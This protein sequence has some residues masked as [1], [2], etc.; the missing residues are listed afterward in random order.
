MG[1]D[2]DLI[3]YAF[4][5]A[6]WE[7]RSPDQYARYARVAL[8]QYRYILAKP[9]HDDMKWPTQQIIA[10]ELERRLGLFDK[11]RTRFAKLKELDQF[12]Q[13]VFPDIVELQ[14]RLIDEKNT[15]SH[16]IPR[17]SR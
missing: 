16:R 4:L 14:L 13:G 11:A 12:K 3:A 10:G 8:R 2:E 6:T 17:K 1:E 5:Q 15:G 7:A 9:E